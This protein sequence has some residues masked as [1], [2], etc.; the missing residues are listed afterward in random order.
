MSSRRAA[1]L[2]GYN[3]FEP[4]KPSNRTTHPEGRK[5]TRLAV[6]LHA[7]RRR[8]PIIV[9]PVMAADWEVE[10]DVTTT[11]RAQLP[12]FGLAV[13]LTLAAIVRCYHLG[14]PLADSMEAKQ[15]FVA[16]RARSIAR[17]PFDPLRNTLD[18][19]DQNGRRMELTEEVPIYTNLLGAAFRLF[20]ERE[21]L[22]HGLS[23]LGMLAA[24]IAFHDLMQR[25][26]GPAFSLI[27]TAW[28]VASPLSTFYGRAVM[29]DSWMLAGMLTS[30]ACYQRYLETGRHRWLLGASAAG[31]LGALFKYYGLIVLIPLAGMTVRRGGWR[32]C[33]SWRFLGLAT[34]M[35]LP[36]GVWMVLVFFRTPNP[37]SSGWA[38][39]QV[40]P[41]LVLQAPGVLLDPRLYRAFFIRFLVYD[42]GPAMAIPLLVAV[43]A[44]VGRR[45]PVPAAGLTLMGLLFF[46]GLAPKLIDHDYYELIL[47]PA[48]A[49][50]GGMGT[51]RIAER[52]AGERRAR[53][54]AC[55][56]G[57]LGLALLVQSPLFM[58]SFF[59]LELGKPIVG[60]R[61]AEIVQEFERIVVIGPG[62][63]LVSIVHYSERE[64]WPI[65]SPTLA[66]DWRE[67]FGRYRA[68]GATHAVLYFG[69]DASNHVRES[70][71]PLVEC[72]PLVERRTGPWG[73]GG[74]WCEYIILNLVACDFTRP[75]PKAL[76]SAHPSTDRGE[77]EGIV[78]GTRH[79][80]FGP[81]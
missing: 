33:V 39:G 63:G 64:G 12:R 69:A 3:R 26:Y 80:A 44:V 47:L 75:V 41:Y 81:S 32:A 37:V 40:Y 19:L 55:E 77:L 48:A 38:Q 28:F 67:A 27:T 34:T 22:G 6:A 50:W 70:F 9:G 79:D 21:W 20:G 25:Q 54:R 52:I 13:L 31:L 42:C 16:N 66:A 78:N 46:V 58:R 71:R 5:K 30:A 7:G 57:I 72:C 15:I 61:V 45:R 11:W 29:P 65:H 74:G 68:E 23:L 59:A 14:A 1:H 56:A 62:I 36:V 76:E 53:R 8:V 24:I 43:A 10:M 35:I 73:R 2:E 51:S 17:P 4:Q 18:F 60:K 49:A